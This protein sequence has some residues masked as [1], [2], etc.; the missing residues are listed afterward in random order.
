MHTKEFGSGMGLYISRL[1]IE[2]M[3]GKIWLEKSI[4]EVGNTF[5]FTLPFSS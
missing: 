4:P 1:L 2:S 3:G 5:S